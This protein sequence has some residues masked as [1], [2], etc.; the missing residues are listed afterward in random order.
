MM[1]W[2]NRAVADSVEARLDPLT[3]AE[4]SQ[5]MARV[6]AK[7]SKPELVVRKLVHRLGFRFRL[8]GGELPG[9]PDL[10]FPSRRKVLFVHG[11]YWHRHEGCSRCRLPKTRLDFWKPKL[12]ANRER[13][14]RNQ[15][16]LDSLGWKWFIVWECQVSKAQ[17][18]FLSE[19]IVRFLA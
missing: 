13:D 10:V 7:N 17:L 6:Q 14:L 12:E 3:P 8:H 9:C 5:R 1:V 11:C 4:R 19:A 16:A 15:A 2:N 18:P